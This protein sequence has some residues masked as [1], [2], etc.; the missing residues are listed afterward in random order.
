LGIIQILEGLW[1]WDKE[2]LTPKELNNIDRQTAWHLAA[3]KGKLE[4]L[5]TLWD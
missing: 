3:V 2:Q 4:A 1:N 5:G